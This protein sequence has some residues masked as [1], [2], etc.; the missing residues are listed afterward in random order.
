M[1]SCFGQ[2]PNNGDPRQEEH[3]QRFGQPGDQL[4]LSVA[5]QDPDQTLWHAVMP[6]GGVVHQDRSVYGMDWRCKVCSQP[7]YTGLGGSRI[8]WELLQMLNLAKESLQ[9]V[10][11]RINDV[12]WVVTPDSNVE[13]ILAAHNREREAQFVASHERIDLRGSLLTL[14]AKLLGGVRDYRIRQKLG[15]DYVETALID[16]PKALRHENPRIREMAARRAGVA[17]GYPNMPSAEVREEMTY[18]L[19][20]EDDDVQ[21]S[22]VLALRLFGIKNYCVVD[23]E[24]VAV[25]AKTHPGRHI[26]FPNASKWTK[27]FARITA[28]GLS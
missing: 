13:E 19:Y 25:S 18:L 5:R 22:A 6:H 12:I 8:S 23:L 20:D 26:P 1:D 21:W 14:L 3:A 27:T 10:K 7:A 16:S 4:G 17:C 28:R 9:P 15:R 24:T 11:C 2:F